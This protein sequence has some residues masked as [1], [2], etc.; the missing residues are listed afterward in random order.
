[1]SNEL[2]TGDYVYNKYKET[3]M[4]GRKRILLPEEE[5]EIIHNTHEA[6]VSREVFD[7]VRIIKKKRIFGGYAKNREESV[8]SDKIFCKECGRHMGFRCDSR[9]K[10]NPNKVYKYRNYYCYF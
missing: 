1:T 8:F 2:Y 4:G 5:W 9:Q 7:K 6:I 3:K 10:K